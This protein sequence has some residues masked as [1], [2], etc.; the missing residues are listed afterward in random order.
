MASDDG[1]F[2]YNQLSNDDKELLLSHGYRPHELRPDEARE[3]LRD[4]RDDDSDTDRDSE[5]AG[6]IGD[7]RE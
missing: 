6:D 1:Y 2:T 7:E 4:L 5:R 3:I